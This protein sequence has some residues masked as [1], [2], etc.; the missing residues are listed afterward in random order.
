MLKNI[1]EEKKFFIIFLITHFL[2]WSLIGTI[3]LVLPTD[4]LE[5]IWWGSLFSF[6]NP[7][8]PPLAGWISYFV[9]NTFKSDM[10]LYFASQAFV[11][12]GLIYTYKLAKFFLEPKQAMLSVVILEGAWV[13]AYIT[14]YYGFNPDVVLLFT[15][16]MVTYYFYRC[17]N[18]SKFYDWIM[19]GTSVGISFMGKY[20]TV[21]LLL[22]MFIWAAIFNRKVFRNKLF[23]MSVIIAF[24]IF[25]PHFIWLIE[26]NFM[27]LSYY[28]AKLETFEWYGHILEPIFFIILQIS[29]IAGVAFIFTLNKFID[30]SKFYFTKK[31]DKNGWFLLILTLT[32]LISQVLMAIISGGNV[33]P[34][35]G[36][37]YWYMTGII[38]FYFLP[39]QI[40]D[41]GFTNTIKTSYIVMLIIFSAFGTM[42][43]VEKSYR[44][45]YP[46]ATVWNDFQKKWQKEFHTPIKYVSG[47]ID[48][49]YPITIYGEPK[50][51][52]LMD[53]PVKNNI[54]IDPKD[55]EKHGVLILFKHK[56]EIEEFTKKAYTNFE[57]NV[58]IIPKEYKFTLTNALGKSRQYRMYYYFIPPKNI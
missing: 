55:V 21:F 13:Y 23:Y 19:L 35:W 7:K 16:P 20:Q 3:R 15:L 30:K 9:F 37:L 33:R 42:L 57:P 54:W 56:N 2:I 14:G 17:M 49:S 43:I 1:S 36:F 18:Y 51:I 46:V 32:P 10:S 8:H 50:S 47:L 58:N 40:S 48:F 24:V 29:L 28:E 31:I 52:N 39:W 41:K 53:I 38:L 44:S 6:G 34:Q 22:G 11:V 4:T 5:G 12:G 26:H 25:L 45:R 27:P